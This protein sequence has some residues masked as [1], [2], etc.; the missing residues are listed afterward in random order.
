MV[1]SLSKVRDRMRTLRQ[2]QR[3]GIKKQPV[4]YIIVPAWEGEEKFKEKSDNHVR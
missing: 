2:S 1:G 4:K 3:N